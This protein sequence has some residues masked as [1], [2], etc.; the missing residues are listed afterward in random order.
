MQPGCTRPVLPKGE[1]KLEVGRHLT[2]KETEAWEIL[3]FE[4]YKS[5]LPVVEQALETVQRPKGRSGEIDAS[6]VFPDSR[7]C[8]FI[9]PDAPAYLRQ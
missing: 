7:P 5:Q 9:F 6:P 1:F 4:L 2:G 3:Y 8:I